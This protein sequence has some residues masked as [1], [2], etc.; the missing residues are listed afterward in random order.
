MWRQSSSFY[1]QHSTKLLMWSLI[2]FSHVTQLNNAKYSMKCRVSPQERSSE[3]KIENAHLHLSP[4]LYE[5]SLLPALQESSAGCLSESP[6][7]LCR[8]LC[9]CRHCKYKTHHWTDTRH[10]KGSADVHGAG[11]QKQ[12]SA[13][14]HHS[15]LTGRKCSRGTRMDTETFMAACCILLRLSPTFV[16]NSLYLDGRHLQDRELPFCY[17]LPAI[18]AQVSKTKK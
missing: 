6:A 2:L 9:L 15:D 1:W 8:S 4:P 13:G 18:T 3:L 12:L 7:Q 17:L 11:P 14:Q 5:P 16:L 10:R